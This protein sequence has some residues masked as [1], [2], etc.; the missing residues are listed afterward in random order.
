MAFDKA[1][2]LVNKYQLEHLFTIIIRFDLDFFQLVSKKMDDWVAGRVLMI[3]A[4]CRNLG[5][6]LIAMGDRMEYIKIK[7]NW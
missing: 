4:I 7:V 2:G 1:K 6:I 3:L 5:I